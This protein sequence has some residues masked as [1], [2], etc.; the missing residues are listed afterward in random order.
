MS[1]WKTHGPEEKELAEKQRLAEA[2]KQAEAEEENNYP[3]R[4]LF[5]VAW[6]DVE[7]VADGG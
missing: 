2:K 3:L 5:H 1:E 7:S 6:A 4:L